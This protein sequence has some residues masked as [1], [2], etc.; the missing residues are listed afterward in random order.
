MNILVLPINL[1][2]Q[3]TL[4]IS[5]FCLNHGIIVNDIMFV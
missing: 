2:D 3:K 4:K 1:K 5:Y